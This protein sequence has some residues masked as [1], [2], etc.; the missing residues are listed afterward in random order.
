MQEK[1]KRCLVQ[2]F[3]KKF[4]VFGSNSLKMSI[5]LIKTLEKYHFIVLFASN[6]EGV[7]IVFVYLYC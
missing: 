3:W 5:C 6:S 2:F 1:K 7:N 4:V